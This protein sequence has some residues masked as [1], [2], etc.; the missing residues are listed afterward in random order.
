MN[1]IFAK[2]LELLLA[3][4]MNILKRDPDEVTVAEL[5]SILMSKKFRDWSAK[6]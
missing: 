1:P 4:L 6:Q 3:F 5:K 2:L